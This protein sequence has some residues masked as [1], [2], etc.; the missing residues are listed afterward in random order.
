[1]ADSLQIRSMSAPEVETLVECA[2]AEGWNPGLGDARAFHAADPAG[3]L[4]G[5]IDGELVSGIAAVAYGDDFGFIGLYIVRPDQRGRGYGKAVWN[6]GMERLAGRTIGLDGVPEQQANYRSQGFVQ[7]YGTTRYSGRFSDAKAAPANQESPT[8]AERRTIA[9][10]ERAYFPAVRAGFLDEW[11]VEPHRT[12]V[13][14]E[15][16]TPVGYGVARA[17]RD[18]VKIGPLFANDFETARDL[19]ESLA[20]GCDDVIHIDVPDRQTQFIELLTDQ[21]FTPGFRTARMYRGTPPALQLDG[22]FAITSLELG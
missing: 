15:G 11:L 5:F 9:D 7:D 20:A 21:G 14:L 4:G 8:E 18:G 17:C 22:V 12:A 1:M 19:V 6:A 3:F 13:H 10:F 2:A 16:E